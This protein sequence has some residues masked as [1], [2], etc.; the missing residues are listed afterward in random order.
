MCGAQVAEAVSAGIPEPGYFLRERDQPD[1]GGHREG[2]SAANGHGD[3]RVHGAGRDAVDD[4]GKLAEALT[5]EA[6]FSTLSKSCFSP[7]HFRIAVAP[8]K[9]RGMAGV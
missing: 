3:R 8:R 7:S 6:G 5:G 4:H 9:C 2:M 1:P